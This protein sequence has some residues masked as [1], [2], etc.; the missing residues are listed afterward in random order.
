[1][2]SVTDGKELEGASEALG[3]LFDRRRA[4]YR[5]TGVPGA[6]VSAGVG[7]VEGAELLSVLSEEDWRAGVGFAD[8]VGDRALVWGLGWVGWVGLGWVG[9]DWFMFCFILRLLGFA[10]LRV[11]NSGIVLVCYVVAFDERAR[12]RQAV[13]TGD[14]GD[15]GCPLSGFMV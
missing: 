3:I 4:F 1:M 14:K 13:S 10:L 12:M 15:L 9:S 6:M 2:L 5:H 11:R 8:W 7:G